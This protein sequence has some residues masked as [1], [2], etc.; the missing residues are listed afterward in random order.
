MLAMFKYILDLDRLTN[1]DQIAYE[2]WFQ[3]F[4]YKYNKENIN[5]SKRILADY[6]LNEKSTSLMLSKLKARIIVIAKSKKAKDNS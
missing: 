2:R 4:N 1:T 6:A 3:Q 5:K